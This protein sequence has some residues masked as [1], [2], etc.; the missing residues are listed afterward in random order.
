MTGLDWVDRNTATESMLNSM[1]RQ[2]I[3]KKMTAK[4]AELECGDLQLRKTQTYMFFV[5][6]LCELEKTLTQ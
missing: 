4:D 3:V 6:K 1:E 5:L 2:Q